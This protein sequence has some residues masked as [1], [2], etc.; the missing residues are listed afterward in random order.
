MRNRVLYLILITVFIAAYY[1]LMGIYL[2][3]LGYYNLESLFFL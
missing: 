2:N 3:R 1:L